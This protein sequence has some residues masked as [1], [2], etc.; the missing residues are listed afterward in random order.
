M[1]TFSEKKIW[2][3]RG[4]NLEELVNTPIP[5]TVNDMGWGGL[6]ATPPDYSERLMR[7]FYVGMNPGEFMMWPFVHNKMMFKCVHLENQFNH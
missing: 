3:E 5:T 1:E 2:P 7:E 6:V 4:V